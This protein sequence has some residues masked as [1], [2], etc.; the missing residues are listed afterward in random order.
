ME[1]EKVAEMML[2][3]SPNIYVNHFSQVNRGCLEFIN[4]MRSMVLPKVVG[5]NC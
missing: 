5:K 4:G 3:L 2:G 1:K